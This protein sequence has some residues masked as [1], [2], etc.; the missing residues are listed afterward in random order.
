VVEEAAAASEAMR[1]QAAKLAKAVSVFRLHAQ[2]TARIPGKNGRID[3]QK[4]H[5]SYSANGP[6]NAASV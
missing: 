6:Y 1:E 5:V 3:V 4:K 2:S